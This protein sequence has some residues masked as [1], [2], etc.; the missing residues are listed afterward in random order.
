MTHTLI[1]ICSATSPQETRQVAGRLTG[2]PGLQLR[3]WNQACPT[4]S[5]GRSMLKT[6][7][8]TKKQEKEVDRSKWKLRARSPPLRR[9]KKKCA[10][11]RIIRVYATTRTLP[12]PTPRRRYKGTQEHARTTCSDDMKA[13][14]CRTTVVCGQGPRAIT[15]DLA[16]APNRRVIST[17]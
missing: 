5:G 16:W 8:P 1:S 4:G 14:C 15:P 12:T 9:N 13:N 10:P 7:T 17:R 3:F 2:L 11:R 6:P